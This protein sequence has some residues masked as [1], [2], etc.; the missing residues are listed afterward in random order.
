MAGIDQFD[1]FRKEHSLGTAVSAHH[2]SLR[3]GDL[4]FAQMSEGLWAVSFY[5]HRADHPD[6]PAVVTD[7]ASEGIDGSGE[8]DAV[9]TRL[10]AYFNGRDEREL[11]EVLVEAGA[12]DEDV[13][14]LSE[15]LDALGHPAV[16]RP[17]IERR[18]AGELPWIVAITLPAGAFV[19]G[20]FGKAGADAWDVVKNF[21]EQIYAARRSTG[22]HDG[23]LKIREGERELILDPSITREG[24]EALDELPPGGYYVWDSESGRWRGA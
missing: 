11:L 5:P 3:D 13:R 17:V 14:K 4:W 6:A 10:G 22:A 9:G 19:T 12:P 15:A 8:A 21:V 1:R 18:S 16:V 2:F 24:C 7:T 23:T 20:F